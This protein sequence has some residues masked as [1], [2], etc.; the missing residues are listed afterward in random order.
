[1]QKIFLTSVAFICC[2]F[3]FSD[4]VAQAAH[5]SEGKPKLTVTYQDNAGSFAESGESAPTA[6]MLRPIDPSQLT[7]PN[8]AAITRPHHRRFKPYNPPFEKK[9][10][11]QFKKRQVD[12]ARELRMSEN[13]AGRLDALQDRNRK[14]MEK[15]MAQIDKLHQKIN[16]IQQQEL[17]DIKLL[18][19]PKQ[20]SRY[21]KI[22]KRLQKEEKN[23]HK[24]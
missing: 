19:T 7:V 20:I 17:S 12:W 16:A 15:I 18:L 13:Q 3:I 1:M 10:F 6:D 9:Y 14:E 2:L 21:D 8:F 5:D 22:I 4:S 23:Y 11:P 24:K